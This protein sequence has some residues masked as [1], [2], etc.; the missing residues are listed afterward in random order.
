MLPR[1]K[2][3]AQWEKYWKFV[4]AIEFSLRFGF[5][6]GELNPHKYTQ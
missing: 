2:V 1:R 4:P 5:H 6:E 3:G